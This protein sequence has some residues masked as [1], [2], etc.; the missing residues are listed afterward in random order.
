MLQ[1]IST[2]RFRVMFMVIVSVLPALVIFHITNQEERN[3]EI[4]HIKRNVLELAQ[5]ISLQEED[6]LDGTRQLLLATSLLGEIKN[7]N[8][9]QCNQVLSEL[10]EN[11]DR[12]LNFGVANAQGEVVCSALPLIEKVNISDRQYFQRALNTQEFSIGGYQVE[13]ITHRPAINL[14]FPILDE[15]GKSIGIVFATLDLNRFAQLEGRLATRLPEGAIL[16]KIDRNGIVLV[17]VPGGENLI[18]DRIPESAIVETVLRENEGVLQATSTDG[19]TWI[20]AFATIR[21]AVYQGNLHIILGQPES[22]LL[23]SANHVF[24]RNLFLMGLLGVFLLIG[25]WYGF[26]I[27]FL[28]QIRMLL[29]VT[30]KLAKGDLSAR[31]QEVPYGA[32]EINELGNYFNQMAISLE[33]RE[34]DLL[35]AYDATIEGW[36]YA[37]DLRDKETEGHTLRVTELTVKLARAAGIPERELVHVRRGALLHDIGKMGVPDHIL[38]KPDKLTHEEWLIM[39]KHPEFALEMLSRI[40]YL[41]P[42]L[43]IP[44]CHHERWDGSG[45]PRGLKGEQIPLAARLFAVVDVWDALRSNRSYRQG[46]PDEKVMEY[47]CQISRTHLD[48]KAVELFMK[49]LKEEKKHLQANS[50]EN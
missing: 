43:D 26:D 12:Y 50:G 29:Y 11:Y 20:Y 30:Q 46:W 15:D 38:L 36:S 9:K 4:N 32:S 8:S 24:N 34:R 39:R 45:Y 31:Y 2:L 47:I 22:I 33:K 13:R 16:T 27:S 7:Y 19:D 48:P 14:G 49:V 17:R 35:Q 42:A 3:N 44:Y 28:R 21:S 37:L 6:F 25:T 18:G 1:I 10:L 5:V 41:K 23:R 40:E